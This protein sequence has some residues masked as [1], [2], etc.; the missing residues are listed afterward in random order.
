ML[1]EWPTFQ[2]KR[3]FILKTWNLQFRTKILEIEH[4]NKLIKEPIH[5]KT[6]NPNFAQKFLG[7]WICKQ[8]YQ[9]I[10]VKT[11]NPNFAPKFL[12]D[13]KCKQTYQPILLK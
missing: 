12:G 13:W 3:G 2:K 6:E 11:E 5:V 9:P 4:V 1:L 10:H 7:N 8:T